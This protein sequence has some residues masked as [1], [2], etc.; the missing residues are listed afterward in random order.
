VAG[1]SWINAYNMSVYGVP[2]SGSNLS[3]MGGGALGPDTLLDT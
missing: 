3:G 1:K 2:H